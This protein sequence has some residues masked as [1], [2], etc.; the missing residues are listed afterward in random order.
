MMK[1]I[2]WQYLDNF[3]SRIW[4]VVCHKHTEVKILHLSQW[5]TL[6]S[7]SPR[8]NLIKTHQKGQWNPLTEIVHAT[9]KPFAQIL[10]KGRTTVK[11]VIESEFRNCWRQTHRT[12]KHRRKE[13]SPWMDHL[14]VIVHTR[15][16]S[17][18][19]PVTRI[20][21]INSHLGDLRSSHP[22]LH[23]VLIPYIFHLLQF[24]FSENHF[25]TWLKCLD[26]SFLHPLT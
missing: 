14:A 18:L 21:K 2:W 9:E 8:M 7:W 19:D 6:V 22:S 23:L 17:N 20:T 25:T 15:S 12:Q 5:K 26:F 24:L 13:C 3:W 16:F 11:K 10:W 4:V 1:I